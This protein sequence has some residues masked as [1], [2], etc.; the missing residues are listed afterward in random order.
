VSDGEKKQSN[1]VEIAGLWVNEPRGGG[2]KYLSGYL[3]G[4]KLLG[5]KNKHKKP[6]SKEPDYRLYV[7][8][9]EKRQDGGKGGGSSSSSGADEG[10][11]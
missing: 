1:M 7:A 3:G 9:N 10:G 4:A 6:D 2:D 11:L 5:F 8:P